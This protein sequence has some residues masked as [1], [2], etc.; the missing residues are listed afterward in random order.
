MNLKAARADKLKQVVG[1]A[2][3]GAQSSNKNVRVDDDV[4]GVHNGII[5]DTTLIVKR[6]LYDYDH[7]PVG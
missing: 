1:V 5:C 7:C 2:F 6:P 3:V 4:R